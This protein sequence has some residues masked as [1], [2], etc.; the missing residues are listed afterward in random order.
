MTWSRT[1][2]G[3]F[4][5]IPAGTPTWIQNAGFAWVLSLVPLSILC[6][7]GMNNLQDVRRRRATPMSRSRRSPI[8]TRWPSCRRFMLYQNSPADG[9]RSAQHV[10]RDSPDMVA[11]SLVMKLAA[12]G[13]MKDNIAKQFAI[14]RNSTPGR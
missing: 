13:P 2:A 7:F 3:S 11:R 12:F 14:F 1:A 8:C 6:W 5:K 4:G 9:A 10:G